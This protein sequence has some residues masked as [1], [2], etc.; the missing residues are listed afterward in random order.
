MASIKKRPDGR[1]RARYRDPSGR[2]H[3]K[4]FLRKIDGERWLVEQEH[5]KQRG[6][7][8]DPA[9]SRE[10]VAEWCQ[11]WRA[12]KVDLRP[13]T[14]SRLDGILRTHVLPAFGSWPLVSVGNADVRAWVSRMVAEGRSAA[15]AR[16]AFF[17]LHDMLNAALADRRLAHNPA[18]GV[19]LPVERHAEQRFLTV[20]EVAALA[21]AIPARF[22]ALVLVA[23]YGGLRFGELAALRRSPRRSW[24]SAT[25]SASVPRR[26]TA[27]DGRFRCHA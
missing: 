23:V 8:I 19:P 7:W 13:S 2:E 12:S 18:E 16:K 27:G 4:H 25:G 17:A 3:A 21:E 5:T 11:G 20:D 9:R 22:R 1:W 24:T 6:V 15:T 10:T 14:L 26:Q